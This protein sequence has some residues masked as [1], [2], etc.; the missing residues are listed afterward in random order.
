MRIPFLVCDIIALLVPPEN[1]PSS[2]LSIW[3]GTAPMEIH[4][5]RTAIVHSSIILR[6]LTQVVYRKNRSM[7]DARMKKVKVAGFDVQSVRALGVDIDEK[8]A[9][10]LEMST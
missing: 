7:R 5:R 1:R 8:T 9:K 2:I 4:Y 3:K 10:L 6:R